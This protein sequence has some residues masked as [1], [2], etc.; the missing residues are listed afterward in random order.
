MHLTVKGCLELASAPKRD[1]FAVYLSDRTQ[2]VKLDG[3]SSHSIHLAQGVPQ[4]SVL[5]PI[6]Y[7]LY[8]SPLS[9]IADQHGMNYHF[10]ADNSQA[11]HFLQDKLSQ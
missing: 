2:F 7:S 8:T 6:L 4:G 1:R 11:L 10:Y 3:S 5:G 9:D